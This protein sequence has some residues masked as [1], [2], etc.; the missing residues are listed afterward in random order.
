[1]INRT[2]V[3]TLLLSFMILT[4]SLAGFSIL[5]FALFSQEISEKTLVINV[6]L[7]VRVFKGNTFVDD[8]TMNDFEVYEDGK[9]QKIEAVYLVKKASIERSE[10]KKRFAPQVSRNFILL[11]EISEYIPKVTDAL[12]YFIHNVIIPSDNLI[13]VTPMKTY[14]M[15]DIALEV[16]S[17]EE[18]ANQLKGLLRK[19]ALAGNSE[20]RSVIRELEGLARSLSASLASGE[21]GRT[22]VQVD[23][24]ASHGYGAM[25]LD[26]QLTKYEVLLSQLENLRH[27]D[28]QQLL[29][30]AKFLKDKEG[31]KYVFLFY[32]KEYIP[33]IEPKILD[34]YIG[35]YQDRPNL[36]Q[37][38][39]D[40][41][42]FFRRDISFDI[43]L[44]KQ[45]YADSSISIHFLFIT[46]PVRRVLGAKMQERSDD[47][48]SAFNEMARA[49]G[50]FVESSARA[51]YLFQRALEASENYYLL[52][53]SPLNYETDGKFKEIKVRVKNKNYKVIYR[54]GYFAD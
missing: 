46:K 39:S 29:N 26:E 20:Y 21:T 34:Q 5:S 50:G 27:V 42:E 3:K 48:F 19:D 38:L 23:E 44:V 11:F 35:M 2:L 7:P 9:L 8:L 18:I 53:Y 4:V 52:Y 51:D 25:S 1:M 22:T 15:S 37:T 41:F 13:F 54:L 28:Q 33:Q 16:K 40:L 17:R 45:V 12:N 10:E 36:Q 31:Q 14:R 24:F 49:T 30:F 47:I 6:E 43:N 32:Q